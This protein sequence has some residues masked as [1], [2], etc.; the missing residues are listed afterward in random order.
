MCDTRTYDSAFFALSRSLEEVRC[1]S[2]IPSFLLRLEQKV[3]P[4]CLDPVTA[5]GLLL[6]VLLDKAPMFLF[7]NE[8]DSYPAARMRLLLK[9]HAAPSQRLQ[10]EFDQLIEGLR[11]TP[12]D[13][14]PALAEFRYVVH[15]H[16]YVCGVLEQTPMPIEL[17][18]DL[19]IEML[20][21]SRRQVV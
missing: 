19:A 14:I 4:R 8:C 5:D 13:R 6:D 9:T 20:P 21:A 17:I 11:E 16:R 12:E 15:V 7:V 2:E 1:R 3:R 10:Q 18:C